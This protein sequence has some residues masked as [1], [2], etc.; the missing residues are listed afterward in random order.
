[1]TNSPSLLLVV[2][3]WFSH[4]NL[5]LRNL[6]LSKKEQ[7][8]KFDHNIQPTNQPNTLRS[9]GSSTNRYDACL[10][11]LQWQ[12]LHKACFYAFFAW[13]V[14]IEGNEDRSHI[15]G[16][17]FPSPKLTDVFQYVLYWGHNKSCYVTFN[18]NLCLSNVTFFFRWLFQ[19]IQGPCLLFSFANF[20]YTDGRTPWK[21][22]QLVAKPL[23]KH[24][25]T[26][27]NNQT[28]MP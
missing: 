23:P 15:S 14:Q 9:I 2:V 3:F 4:R 7:N 16:W 17:I 1:L 21:S 18:F 13:S 28:S 20:F 27:T 5:F 19:A 6:N 24:R 8:P 25:T 26:Q 12:Q 22:D 11:W 10:Y